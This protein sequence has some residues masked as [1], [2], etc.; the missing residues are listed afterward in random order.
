M[1]GWTQALNSAVDDMLAEIAEVDLP[2][3]P[4]GF[5]RDAVQQH[6]GWLAQ[7]GFERFKVTVNRYYFQFQ[8]TRA[9]D[10]QMRNLL[11]WWAPQSTGLPFELAR[12]IPEGWTGTP[13][14]A[15][16]YGFFVGLLH[17]RT[18]Q[19]DQFA[20]LPQLEEP[21]IGSPITWAVN[22]RFLSEDLLNSLREFYSLIAGL[23]APAMLDQQ[24]KR[25][26][27]IEI[28]AG[29]G[30]FAWMARRTVNAR[31]VIVDIPPALFVS[32][33]YLKH[34]FP[35]A[36][37]SEFKRGQTSQGISDALEESEFIFLTPNQIHLLPEQSIDFGIAIS[38]LHEMR[39]EAIRYY[40]DQLERLVRYRVYLKQ[41]HALYHKG[42]TVL[43]HPV[44]NYDYVNRREDYT[45]GPRFSLAYDRTDAVDPWLFER[46]FIAQP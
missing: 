41:W 28:G 6:A 1:T 36:S 40:M 16:I 43:L 9:D 37:I 10:R 45:L 4:R 33:T 27:F 7:Y 23:E 31:Y 30:R 34:C 19:I 25:P 12:Q 32:Q 11:A 24:R 2:C 17:E 39:P 22:G 26:W 46:L 5:W 29:Y 38:S 42:G 20:L 13:D 15:A 21:R 8:P 14:Q 35:N 44:E 18:R 3:S